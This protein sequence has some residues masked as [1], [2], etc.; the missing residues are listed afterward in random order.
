MININYVQSDLPNE[1]LLMMVEGLKSLT[2]WDISTNPKYWSE[3]FIDADYIYRIHRPSTRVV[4]ETGLVIQDIVSAEFQTQETIF[5]DFFQ[6]NKHGNNFIRTE[7]K[8]LNKICE[9]ITYLN[10]PLKNQTVIVYNDSD[11]YAIENETDQTIYTLSMF[12]GYDKNPMY[13]G[14]FINKYFRKFA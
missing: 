14:W 6:I 3:S 10:G 4:E 1:D 7:K 13:R 11:F 9:T 8:P 2:Q 5:P 12:W